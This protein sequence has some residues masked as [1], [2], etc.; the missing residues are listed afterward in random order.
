V[1]KQR[2]SP[3][4]QKPQVRIPTTISEL[5]DLQD[6][7]KLRRLVQLIVE[8]LLTGKLASLGFI[9]GTPVSSQSPQPTPVIAPVHI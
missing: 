9:L 3:S 5:K 4:Q 6:N 1:A 8:A 2:A 7:E